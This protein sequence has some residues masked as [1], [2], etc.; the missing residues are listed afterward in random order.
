MY[1][2]LPQNSPTMLNV[3]CEHMQRPHLTFFP[4]QKTG[5]RHSQSG[6][7]RIMK[8]IFYLPSTGTINSHAYQELALKTLTLSSPQDQ[9]CLVLSSDYGSL[10]DVSH[11]HNMYQ[12]TSQNVK[13]TPEDF[14]SQKV[15][16]KQFW[17]PS[18]R[19]LWSYLGLLLQFS[20]CS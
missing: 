13:F 7:K 5:S 6:I 4:L 9:T 19:W 11:L 3:V 15:S 12:Q 17:L 14:S 8:R 10:L 20:S 18:N 16:L 2:L 1:F